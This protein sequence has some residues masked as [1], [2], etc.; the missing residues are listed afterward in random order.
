MPLL[1]RW[2]PN[3]ALIIIDHHEGRFDVAALVVVAQELVAAHLV[4]QPHLPPDRAPAALAAG[5][6]LER[7]VRHR[8]DLRCGAQILDSAIALVAGHLPD[9]KIVRHR[10]AQSLARVRGRDA[11]RR[12]PKGQPARG[13]GV[14]R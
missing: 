6:A 2:S 5:V 7:D 4:A 1:R 14:H 8:A 13:A 9:A 11:L 12:E 10:L 3:L